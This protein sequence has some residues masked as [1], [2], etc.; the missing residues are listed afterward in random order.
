M[1]YL[2]LGS[3]P[4]GIAAAKAVRKAERDAEIVIATDEKFERP[5][6]RPLLPDLITGEMDLSAIWDPQGEDLAAKGIE[7][8]PGK[9]AMKVDAANRRV[10]FADGS[11]ESFDTLLVATGGRPAISPALRK[12]PGS[13][14]PFDSLDDAQRIREKAKGKGDTVV[15]GPGFLGIVASVALRRVGLSVVWLRPDLP[16]IGYPISGE[17]EASILDNVRNK[18]ITI[19]DGIDISEIIELDAGTSDVR[20]SDGGKIRCSMIVA[21]TERLPSVEF[22]QGSDVHVGIGILVDDHLRTSVPNIY[23][24]GDCAELRDKASGESRINFGWRSAIKQGQLAGEN[25]AGGGKLFIG[26]QEDYFWMLFGSALD[27]RT[28]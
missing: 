18:G 23:A 3:G 28:R 24:A 15:Y 1:R 12:N 21:A 8:R 26:K 13:V 25:M 5:Y 20:T 27:D 19:R 6:L 22:L 17:L 10:S 2:I 7:V 16:R 14:F 4:A 11:E 9:R